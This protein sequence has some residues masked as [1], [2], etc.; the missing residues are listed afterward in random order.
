MDRSLVLASCAHTEPPANP[1]FFSNPQSHRHTNPSPRHNP[2]NRHDHLTGK[3][4]HDCA[5]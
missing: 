5:S 4:Q 3:R 1:Y 2:P